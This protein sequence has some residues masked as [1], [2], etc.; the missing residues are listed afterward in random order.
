MTKRIVTILLVSCLFFY[1]SAQSLTPSNADS[2]I[3]FTIKNMGMD[4]N[5][6][7]SNLAGKM[8][9]NPKNLKSSLFDVTVDVITVNTGVK[10]RDDHLQ[11]SDFF[12]AAKFP[13][14]SIKTTSIQ[15]KG[16]NTYFAKAILNIHGN[17]KNIQFDFTA[18]P[19]GSG[20][21]FKAGFTIDRK[22]FKVGGN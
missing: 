8:N 10:K 20:Y 5:G 15:A 6:T 16:N 9:F 19:D 12:D 3:S 2:K 7:F 18:T 22:D 21:N 13:T 4:V 14:I 17:S 1:S 11:K